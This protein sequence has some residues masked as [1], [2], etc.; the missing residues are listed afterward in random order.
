MDDVINVDV[1]QPDQNLAHFTL[2]KFIFGV[3]R[4]SKDIF[5]PYFLSPLTPLTHIFKTFNLKMLELELYTV[6]MD[7]SN[8]KS[9]SWTHKAKFLSNLRARWNFRGSVM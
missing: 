5:T 9:N 6:M 1:F 4:P 3:F 2:L 7:G 8:S